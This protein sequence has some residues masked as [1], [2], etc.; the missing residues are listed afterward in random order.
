MCFEKKLPELRPAG[1]LRPAKNIIPYLR[2]E[3]LTSLRSIR[4]TQ[5]VQHSEHKIAK[6]FRQAQESDS[7]PRASP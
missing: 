7:R 2:N 1:M 5:N 6:S 3:E 4:S